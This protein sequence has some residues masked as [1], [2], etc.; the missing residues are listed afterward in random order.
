MSKAKQY[1]KNMADQRLVVGDL[2][3]LGNMKG[4]NLKSIERRVDLIQKQASNYK[5]VADYWTALSDDGV[6]TPIEKNILLKEW[7]GIEESYAA[8]QRQAQSQNA[9]NTPVFSDYTAA[10]N[11]LHDYL[12]GTL[13][14][15]DNMDKN[16]GIKDKDLY[17][18]MYSDYYYAEK[19]TLLS[20]TTGI[21]ENFQ[22]KVLKSLVDEGQ[23]GDYGLYRGVIYYYADGAWHKAGNGSYLGKY[24]S[25]I[26]YL[27]IGDF[28]LAAA[29]F[30]ANVYLATE[31]AE[32]IK[33]NNK[34]LAVSIAF[35]KG[36]I[37]EGTVK[38]WKKVNNRN[39]WKYIIAVDD[40]I[41][42]NAE[43]P[44]HLKSFV[45]ITAKEAVPQYLGLLTV[46]PVLAT[47]MYTPAGGN[48]QQEYHTGDWFTWGGV[49]TTN[50]GNLTLTKGRVY[51]Y[52]GDEWVQ[53]DEQDSTNGW[54]LMTA[55][56]DI[57]STLE[58]GAGYFSYIFANMLLANEAFINRL[59]A[60]VIELKHSTNESGEIRSSN[61]AANIDGFCLKSS[62]FFEC[63]D[64]HFRGSIEAGPL[65]A[66]ESSPGAFSLSFN[67]G[68]RV[69]DVWRT[70]TDFIG[71]RSSI[72]ITGSYGNTDLIRVRRD[73]D[74]EYLPVENYP[75]TG[76]ISA[77]TKKTYKS[78]DY[79]GNESEISYEQYYGEGIVGEVNDPTGIYG[80]LYQ[81]GTFNRY[82]YKAKC[83]FVLNGNITLVCN[84][85]FYG[86]N[87]V[88]HDVGEAIN[89]SGRPWIRD[90]PEA[91]HYDEPPVFF[92]KPDEF[93]DSTFTFAR[94]IDE[95][96]LE[97]NLSMS[98]N[99]DGNL[100]IFENIPGYSDSLQQG[101][102]YK[103]SS[104]RLFVKLN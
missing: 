94:T 4:A 24:V 10:Y 59:G 73:E 1:E 66:N 49:T 16:T 57:L 2:V 9:V 61:Y 15:F 5:K 103:D 68:T 41:S 53:L 74:W 23:D 50:W 104:G 17:S 27:S 81:I 46:A 28:F 82:I 98:G 31:D 76:Y 52:Y 35:E 62:G 86:F 56:P 14:V 102:V 32:I 18:Q 44:E 97:N 34:P 85:S 11:A 64:G 72:P 7:K 69:Y 83:R 38:G 89:Q 19:F 96:T 71:H 45:N 88:N 55:L 33:A 63:H 79:L 84:L 36:F 13:K 93:R 91:R 58:A 21:I 87:W 77:H 22:F 101:A 99:I 100:M 37:Y 51:K 29:N 70:L 3:V 30:N 47:N 78:T 20:F 75:N 67:A 80:T 40:L 65:I 90:Y 48:G 8:I 42:I 92:N 6:I 39:D 43:I 60:K 95:Y 12:Y 54:Y 25:G 26:P